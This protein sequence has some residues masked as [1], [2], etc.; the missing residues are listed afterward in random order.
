MGTTR[1]RAG[2]DRIRQ[3]AYYLDV[4]FVLLLLI[5]ILI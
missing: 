4:V 1:G 5:Q 3:K 2:C